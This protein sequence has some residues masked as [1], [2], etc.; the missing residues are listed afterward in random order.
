MKKFA[1]K[2][3][4]ASRGRFKS[5]QRGRGRGKRPGD[6]PRFEDHHE[7]DE[8]PKKKKFE[9]FDWRAKKEQLAK[10]RAGFET[11]N[12]HEEVPADYKP[13]KIN[14]S[15]YNSSDEDEED[16]FNADE[17]IQSL[18]RTEKKKNK[19]G[20]GGF[21]SLGLSYPVYKAI[22]K[23]GYKVPTPIQREN[24]S[25][26]SRRKGCCSHGP[27]WIR[28]DSRVSHPNG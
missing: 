17:E 5:D 28:K 2:K 26:G 7:A 9:P 22:I 11:Q 3:P 14:K 1:N 23:K 4:Q 18:I 13:I 24:T 10:K 12:D 6:R 20:G 8:E 25:F 15:D 16:D 19:S 27:N 21:Q